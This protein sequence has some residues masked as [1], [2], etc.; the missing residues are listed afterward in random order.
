MILGEREEHQHQCKHCGRS[1][2]VEQSIGWRSS[3]EQ[4]TCDSCYNNGKRDW[5]TD[6][7]DE[8]KF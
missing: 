2:N 6:Y 5:A 3:R 4:F 1:F 7:D 8:G